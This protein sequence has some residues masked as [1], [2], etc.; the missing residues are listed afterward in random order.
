MSSWENLQGRDPELPLSLRLE[1]GDELVIEKWLRVLPDKRYVGQGVWRG[2]VVLV[3][4]FVGLSACRDAH[5][6]R[7]GIQILMERKISTPD[8]LHDEMHWRRACL[9]TR[10]LPEA[11]N[12]ANRWQRLNPKLPLNA[13]QLGCIADAL[14]LL[15]LLHQKGVT[16]GDLHLGNILLDHDQL[17]VLDGDSVRAARGGVLSA[18]DALNGLAEFFCRFSVDL[19][20]YLPQLEF[21]YGG[22]PAS[23]E[24]LQFAIHRIQQKRIATHLR[25]RQRESTVIAVN[26]QRSSIILLDRKLMQ[27][28]GLDQLMRDANQFFTDDA[29]YLKQGNSA[30]VIAVHWRG[31]E[32]ILKRY[33][34]KS[35]GH[36]LSRCWRPSRAW[37]SWLA[38]HLLA[39]LGIPAARAVAVRENRWFGLRGTAWL[40]QESAGDED[41]VHRWQRWVE[42]DALPP[43]Q[44]RVGMLRLLDQ[45]RRWH[46][47]HGDLKGSNILWTGSG[48]R[49]IDLDSMQY[50]RSARAHRS[51]WQK[52][53]SRFLRNWPAESAIYRYFDEN[54]P[55]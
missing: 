48:W 1:Q 43:E 50:F 40:L 24:T 3:K 47:G 29:R 9:L 6:E 18:K 31:R 21:A 13:T 44:E 11:D 37:R 4:L 38:S 12:L 34:I 22:Y 52:D 5:R 46:I 26:H 41:V 25:K 42:A 54:L 17:L 49:L 19:T 33:N 2:E 30:T 16:H 27:S 20:D 51:A 14:R 39:F 23:L 36:W 53:K 45:L 10:F 7:R 35:V 28:D 15:A 32:W 8:L 55:A